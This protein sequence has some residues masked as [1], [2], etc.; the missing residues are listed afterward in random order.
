MWYVMSSYRL[1]MRNDYIGFVEWKTADVIEQLVSLFVDSTLPY[2]T[3]A[4]AAQALY[5][6]VTLFS[7]P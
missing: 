5:E 7:K 2:E 6:N 4:I 3:S 1:V